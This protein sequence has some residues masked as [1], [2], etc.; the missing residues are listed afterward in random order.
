MIKDIYSQWEVRRDSLSSGNNRVVFNFREVRI[1]PYICYDLRFPVW[2]SNRNDY[3][4]M[5]YSANWPENRSEVWN[6]LL[7]A[8]AIE[9]QCYVIG[10][11]RIGIDGNGIK[12][13]GN[14]QIINPKGN[15]IAS[16]MVNEE[17]C[18]S[19]D[20]SMVAICLTSERNF[21]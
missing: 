16:A 3:D 8:R 20:L 7:R 19:A 15:I 4:L 11:N 10:A 1:S 2:C 21:L 14:S 18:V 5:I 17:S 6:T 9:N 12:Y 13:S